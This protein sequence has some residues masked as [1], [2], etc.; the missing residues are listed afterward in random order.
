VVHRRIEL[1]A[2]INATDEF[3]IAA[4]RN[5]NAAPQSLSVS[6][7]L[8]PFDCEIGGAHCVGRIDELGAMALLHHQ[9]SDGRDLSEKAAAPVGCKGHGLLGKLGIPQQHFLGLG[10]PPVLG[11][12][13]RLGK[14]VR[15]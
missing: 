8:V 1:K 2:G 11:H 6:T 3:G 7:P 9:A 14:L 4:K 5:L 15:R 10:V 12:N 13:V